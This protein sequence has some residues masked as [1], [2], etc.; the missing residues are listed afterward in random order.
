MK[1]VLLVSF[2]LSVFSAYA[3]EEVQSAA[4]K[5]AVCKAIDKQ[6]GWGSSNF[7]SGVTERS[8][9]DEKIYFSE[10]KPPQKQIINGSW[11]SHGAEPNSERGR[12]P[13]SN[14]ACYDR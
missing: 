6:H 11:S 4:I 1:I 9:L 5:E 8:C 2:V 14:G 12:G 13:I 3:V 10:T 7:L